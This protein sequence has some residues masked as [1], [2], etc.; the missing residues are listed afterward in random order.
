[1]FTGIVQAIGTI[2]SRDASAA[3]VTFT[4]AAGGVALRQGD[5]VA[6]NGVCHTVEN[7]DGDRFAF[8]SVGETLA[9]TT[10]DTVEPGHKVNVEPAATPQTALGGHIVQGHVDGV[11][12][13]I[14]FDRAGKDHLLTIRLPGEIFTYAVEKGSIA[15]DGT[16]L[17]IVNA[18]TDPPRVTITII[19]YT[20]DNTIASGYAPG[21]LVNVEADI[22]GKY[23][24]K[25]VEEIL[26]KEQS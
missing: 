3:G 24:R 11:G 19:P 9:R 14:A 25:Y 17:T 20:W 21:T 10:L 6:I 22:V 12:E 7:I 4:V 5:S 23:V 15:V 2:T 18:E 26:T 13:V 1:M 8:T 16:S